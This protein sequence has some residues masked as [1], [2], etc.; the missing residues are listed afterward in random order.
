MT[1]VALCDCQQNAGI[2]SPYRRPLRPGQTGRQLR[3]PQRS[4][5][6]KPNPRERLNQSL[7]RAPRIRRV[8]SKPPVASSQ[9]PAGAGTAD[10]VT[11]VRDSLRATKAA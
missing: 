10:V 2:H 8:S 6:N 5:T 4:L 1:E 9:N 11:A 3:A 7:G